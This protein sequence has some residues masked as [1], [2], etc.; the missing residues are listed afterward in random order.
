M[1]LG[2][3]DWTSSARGFLL[4]AVLPV[5]YGL[6]GLA[7]DGAGWPPALA[8]AV[9]LAVGAAFLRRQRASADPMIDVRLFADRAFGA[10]LAANTLVFFVNFGIL[11]LFAQYLQLVVGLSPLAAGLWTVPQ[12]VAFIAASML[13]PLAVR[14]VRP[15][16]VMAAGLAMLSRA[17]GASGLALAVAA[18]VVFSFGLAPLTTLAT[19]LMLA[20]APP[21]RAGA[22]AAIS[23]TSSEF[24]GTMGIAV[25]GS[26][27]TAVYRER[28]ADAVPAG[29][30]P[31]A[32]GAARDTLGGAVAAA[33]GLPGPLGGELLEASR[34]AFTQALQTA[35]ATS[36][37]IA[38]CIAVLVLILLRHILSSP[39]P[40]ELPDHRPESAVLDPM[41]E[42]S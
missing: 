21:E 6:K 14:R 33:D 34:E 41:P 9:G 29:V 19:D 17:D 12:F 30:P 27:G 37:A 18:S 4:V 20:A 1:I 35:A 10:S 32:A 8:I 25:L 15:A 3:A 11:L 26:V 40:E 22:A 23:K 5:A 24:G 16:F 2:R 28:V 7:Q 31:D 36:A 13:A 42:K 39:K 38:L